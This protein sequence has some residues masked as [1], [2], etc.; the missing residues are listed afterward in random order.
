MVLLLLTLLLPALSS[1][2]QKLFFSSAVFSSALSHLSA[3]N[4]IDGDLSSTA[5]SVCNDKEQEIWMEMKLSN[6]ALVTKVT[7]YPSHFT[8]Q[9]KT[10]ERPDGAKIFQVTPEGTEVFCGS[11][12]PDWDTKPEYYEIPCRQQD[13]LSV[14]LMI[15]LTKTGAACLHFMEIQAYGSIVSNVEHYKIS[16]VYSPSSVSLFHPYPPGTRREPHQSHSLQSSQH[17]SQW[18]LPLTPHLPLEK[19]V[20]TYPLKGNTL[21]LFR[22]K[23]TSVVVQSY[24]CLVSQYP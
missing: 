9:E 4:A 23:T 22:L 2:D 1:S 17:S 18:Q 21:F 20:V 11:Y 24:V 10:Y 7:I 6:L 14:G 19:I 12:H 8:D 5:H 16:R 3:T 15:R 13:V